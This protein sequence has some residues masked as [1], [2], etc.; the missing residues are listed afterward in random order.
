MNFLA[1]KPGLIFICLCKLLIVQD[2][3]L[4]KVIDQGKATEM[5]RAK[6]SDWE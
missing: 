4:Q 2:S 1:P 5:E 3:M 6:T